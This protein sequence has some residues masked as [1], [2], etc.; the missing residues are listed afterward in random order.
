VTPSGL[1]DHSA[2]IPNFFIMGHHF[3]A[4]AF[5]SAAS[6]SGVCRSR[7][8][9]SIPS[10]P[11][12]E[13]S[14]G[15]AIASM[16]AVLSLPMMFLGVRLGANNPYHSEWESVGNPMSAKVGISGANGNRV[17]PVYRIGFNAP[18]PHLW[19][20]MRGI[21]IEVNLTGEQVL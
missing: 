3:S 2:L 18:T 12:R 17:S 15:S 4:S 10:S 11:S 14:D 8:K 19:E 7:G 9:I 5:M 21:E 6:A 20:L 13:R 16:A 1:A